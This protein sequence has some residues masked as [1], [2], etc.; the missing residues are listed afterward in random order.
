[1]SD[2]TSPEDRRARVAKLQA[3]ARRSERQ[4]A[5]GILGAVVAVAAVLVAWAAIAIIGAAEDRE[6]IE[7]ASEG[8]IDGVETFDDLTNNHVTGAVDYPQT[9]SV[10]GDH[11]AVWLNCG[12]YTEPVD[13]MQTTHSLEHGAVWIGYDPAI[14]AGQLETLTQLAQANDYVVLSPV[15]GVPLPVT[16]SA[17]GYQLQL[18]SADDPRLEVFIEKYQQSEQAP[19]P[20]APCTGG[21]EGM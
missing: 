17:W 13:P 19:E 21:V 8:S 9:P 4:R 14:E 3:S 10:G 2:K 11:A 5:F 1:M 16:A 7:A 12:V 18:E 15:E 20:G 6:E